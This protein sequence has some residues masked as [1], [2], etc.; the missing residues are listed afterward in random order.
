MTLLDTLRPLLPEGATAT[1]RPLNEYDGVYV[2]LQVP[3][4]QADELA[5]PDGLPPEDLHITLVYIGKAADYDA[6]KARRL[7]SLCRVMTAVT[8]QLPA[9]E[10]TLT[11]PRRFPA[12]GKEPCY[13]AV[14][15]PWIAELQKQ[16]DLAA[17]MLG[18][19]PSRKFPVF[20]PH[21]TLAYVEPGAPHPRADFTPTPVTFT[22]LELYLPGGR[23]TLPFRGAQTL[24]KAERAP[25]VA[26]DPR[27]DARALYARLTGDLLALRAGDRHLVRQGD[28]LNARH[29]EQFTRLARA[30]RAPRGS[31][32]EDAALHHADAARVGR[33]G[34]A[35]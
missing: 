15:A 16:V 21:V 33:E 8:D 20:H 11:E 18:L 29:G 10:A 2:C 6:S 9:L 27:A 35:V 24:A 1:E 26:S 5:V 13:L 22:G 30:V 17:F 14:D 28:A 3:R 32:L 4:A 31:A 25:E 19:D 12:E 7:A 23:V 34:A